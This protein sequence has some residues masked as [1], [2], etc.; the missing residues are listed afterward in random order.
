MKPVDTLNLFLGLANRN[1]S[2][3]VL[4]EHS[5]LLFQEDVCRQDE[6]PEA[7]ERLRTDQ[8]VLIEA[9]QLL[10]VGEQNLDI[11]PGCQVTHKCLRVGV[12]V[13]RRPKAWLGQLAI[14]L[15]FNHNQLHST[16]LLNRASK[17]MH[18]DCSPTAIL[19][20]PDGLFVVVIFKPLGVRIKREPLPL[21]STA[22]IPNA[23][24]SVAFEPR[25]DQEAALTGGFPD[26]L[27]AVPRIEQD[28]RA[29]ATHRLKVTD[30]GFHECDLAAERHAFS[31]TRLL[32]SIE[33][34]SERALTTQQDVQRL[35]KTVPLDWATCCGR[36]MAANG[37]HLLAAHLVAGAVIA[38]QVSSHSGCFRA[39]RPS[40]ASRAMVGM[41]LSHLRGKLLLKS[42]SP[43]QRNLRRFPGCLRQK[44]AQA[45]HGRLD[46]DTAQQP[47]QRSCASAQQQTHQHDHKV[48]KLR[49]VKTVRERLGILA[50]PRVY[51]YNRDSHRVPPRSRVSVASPLYLK[52]RDAPTQKLNVQR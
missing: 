7:N 2:L 24:K 49:T 11:P 18:I 12:H 27:G 31:H 8:L 29:C 42:F 50:K 40:E 37:L 39:A 14:A 52:V 20:R 19:S 41:E 38:D 34:R 28:V 35:N 21:G 48:L 36:V 10:H 6:R 3:P 45:C 16:Q 44:T 43:P 33:L 15:L 23:N 26:H 17:D 1:R 9:Q 51:A 25:R 22:L 5:P 13:A 30:C 32:L 4:F 46:R 47:R